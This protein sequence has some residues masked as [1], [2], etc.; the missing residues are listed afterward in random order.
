MKKAYI[1]P[2]TTVFAI[3]PLQMLA[4]SISV[5]MKDGAVDAGTSFSAGRGWSSEGWA[6]AEE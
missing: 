2:A 4:A 6:D 1:A 3:E 5:D